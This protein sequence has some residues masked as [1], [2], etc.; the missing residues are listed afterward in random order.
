MSGKR[1]KV[2]L[3]MEKKLEALFRIDKGEP[4]KRVATDLGVGASTV[5]DWKKNRKEIEGFC[6]K[7]V[8]RDSLGNRGTIK[9]A[10]NVMLDEA[11]YVWYMQERENGV[12]ISGPMLRQKALSLNNKFS[13]DPTFT[14]SVGWLGRW[15]ARHGIRLTISGEN[16]LG[17]SI[18]ND[19][20]DHQLLLEDNLVTVC[21]STQEEEEAQDEE[22]KAFLDNRCHEELTS[23]NHAEATEMLQKLITYFEHQSETLENELITLNHLR[24]RAS[25]KCLLALK[26]EKTSDFLK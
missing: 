9:K 14:A 8:S 23:L 13:G 7:M 3:T 18:P 19:S 22:T 25:K 15:K 17:E 20:T 2:T 12:S 6:A 1:K 4:M 10:K 5:S 16:L 11:L 26:Q 21:L 24:D